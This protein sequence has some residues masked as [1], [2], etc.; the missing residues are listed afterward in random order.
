MLDQG[1]QDGINAV[2]LGRQVFEDIE[3]EYYTHILKKNL[4]EPT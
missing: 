3:K 4:V 1:V 2:K